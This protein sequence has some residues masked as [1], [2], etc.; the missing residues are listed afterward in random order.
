MPR[1]QLRLVDRQTPL[2]L[3]C[4]HRDGNAREASSCWA[5][6]T[7]ADLLPGKRAVRRILA[8]AIKEFQE[9]RYHISRSLLRRYVRPDSRTTSSARNTRLPRPGRHDVPGPGA[10]DK[11]ACSSRAAP[12]SP[13]GA[14]PSRDSTALAWRGPRS[15][16]QELAGH[17]HALDLVGALVDLGDRGPVGSFRR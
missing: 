17:D 3:T 14:N 13:G 7:T 2:R 1:S 4:S 5:D 11:G 8:V 6:A 12:S 10:A 9:L 16:L 15:A